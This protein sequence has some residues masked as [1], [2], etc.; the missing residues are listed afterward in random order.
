MF[1]HYKEKEISSYSTMVFCLQRHAKVEDVS[2][3]KIREDLQNR[4][5]FLRKQSDVSG[6]NV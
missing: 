6:N 3:K 2:L 1:F 4:V 5:D